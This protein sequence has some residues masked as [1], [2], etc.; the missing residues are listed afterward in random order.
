M[1]HLQFLF[2]T[3]ASVHL[4]HASGVARP[5]ETLQ[6][7]LDDL[8]ESNFQGSRQA[9]TEFAAAHPQD[10]L[11]YSLKAA[12]YLFAELDRAGVL[13]GDFMRDD[14]NLQDAVEYHPDKT[15]AA[16]LDD[17]VKQTRKY[18]RSLLLIDPADR[19]AL[20][21]MCIVT[22][23]Q[24]DYLA[25]V[26]HKLRE[27]YS[28]IR[29]SNVYAKRLLQSDPTAYD[30]YLTKGF[31]EYLVANLPFYLRWM[32]SLD[33]VTGTREEGLSD[34]EIAAQSGQYLRPFAQL[35]LAMFYLREK[36]EDKTEELLAQLT[37]EY[38]LNKTFRSEYDKLRA[39]RAAIHKTE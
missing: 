36:K 15:N 22:G 33:S 25:L 10:P 8:Y 27:S 38:P 3:I 13:R 1:K 26:E 31:T 17:A 9:L 6:L 7:A 14:G 19:N 2:L 37:T 23:V 4:C 18:A 5:N 24:R 16:A 12:T 21:A 32:M 28:F 34:L 35:L 39:K 29:E 11:P 20:L 30:A